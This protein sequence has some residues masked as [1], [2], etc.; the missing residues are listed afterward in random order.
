MPEGLGGGLTGN[1]LNTAAGKSVFSH[2]ASF[3]LPYPVQVLSRDYIL[4]LEDFARVP[5]AVISLPEDLKGWITGTQSNATSANEVFSHSASF[6]LTYPF[7]V[8]SGDY[9]L[10]LEDLLES[11]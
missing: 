6:R 3:R 11:H 7:L 1:Q 8:L 10:R 2:S 9:I 4:S 5:P